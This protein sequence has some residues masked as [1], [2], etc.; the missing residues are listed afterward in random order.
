MKAKV[1]DLTGKEKASINLPKC[2]GTTVRE[3]IVC[4]V[5][6][7]KKTEQP[8]A[9]SLMAGNQSSASGK[10]VHKRH[11]WKSQYGR[12]MSRIPRKTM[13]RRGTQ[14][15]WVGTTV[16]NARG[17]RRAHPPRVEARINTLKI[18]KKE[19]ELALIS[20][21]SATTSEKWIKKKYETLKNE[22]LK[23][24]LPVVVES[25][26]VS[27]KAKE[28]LTGL[29]KIL[30]KELENIAF[31]EKKIRCGKGKARGRRYKSN[32][33]LLLVLGNDEKVKTGMFDVTQVKTLNVAEL[34]SG[35]V[36]RLTVYTEKAIKD[37]EEKFK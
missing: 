3:D 29:K 22:K 24:E 23:I 1:L 9:P 34:A 18:N 25:K 16:P 2:F 32:A 10:I 19:L 26:I 12:G 20:A 11:C 35:G 21:L 31:K 8:Y 6:E 30:G 5:I 13:S 36:G 14:F 37:L 7:T 33:G 28:L 15:N 27:L 4:K 17:G